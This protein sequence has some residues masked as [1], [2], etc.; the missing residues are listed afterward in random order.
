MVLESERRIWGGEAAPADASFVSMT[1]TVECR[2]LHGKRNGGPAYTSPC[3]AVSRWSYCEAM[4]L[5]MVTKPRPPHTL[6][7]LVRSL[8]T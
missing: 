3:F 8:P 5:A 6:Q 7:M 2:H 4:T 1:G